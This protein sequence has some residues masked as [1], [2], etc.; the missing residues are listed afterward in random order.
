M[1]STSPVPWPP[2][3]PRQEPSPSPGPP[4]QA[5]RAWARL[6]QSELNFPHVLAQSSFKKE[7]PQNAKTG[8]WVA[9]SCRVVPRQ[10][11]EELPTPWV[12]PLATLPVWGTLCR[13]EHPTPNGDPLAPA[14]SGLVQHSAPPS[15]SESHTAGGC[16]GVRV[17]PPRK[18]GA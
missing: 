9:W 2:R 10:S 18:A 7:R 5:G 11:L 16:R 6:L 8:C 17:P 1:F 3:T 14:E 13:T 12:Q 15:S 4:R